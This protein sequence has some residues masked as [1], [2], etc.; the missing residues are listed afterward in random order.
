M[1]A[2]TPVNRTK[3]KTGVR[4]IASRI[5]LLIGELANRGIELRLLGE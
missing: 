5:R 3:F 1:H 4:V 2:V